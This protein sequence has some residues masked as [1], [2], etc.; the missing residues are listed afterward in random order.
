MIVRLV[1][2]AV[3]SSNTTCNRSNTYTLM[4]RG[5]VH[6]GSK[7]WT[8]RSPSAHPGIRFLFNGDVADRGRTLKALES[9]V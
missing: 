4:L 3:M 1:I 9:R 7:P 2:T 5:M 8:P 6:S